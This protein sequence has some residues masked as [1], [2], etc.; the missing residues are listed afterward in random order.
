MKTT[1]STTRSELSNILAG[2]DAHMEPPREIAF[3]KQDSGQGGSIFIAGAG[4]KKK[5]ARIPVYVLSKVI[6]GCKG[7]THVF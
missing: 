1:G 4:T 2:W 6:K 7:G 3:S 5:L